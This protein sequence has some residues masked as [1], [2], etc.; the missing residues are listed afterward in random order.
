MPLDGVLPPDR[1]D[2]AFTAHAD[3]VQSG[4][5]GQGG[6]GDMNPVE[7]QANGTP[8]GMPNGGS[9]SESS[10]GTGPKVGDDHQAVIPVLSSRDS[11][12]LV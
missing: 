2:S 12:F 11:E 8:S 10:G 9:G 3:P 4:E 5:S 6:I 7:S 1:F